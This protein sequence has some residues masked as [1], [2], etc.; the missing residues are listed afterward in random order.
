MINWTPR[1][2]KA[3]DFARKAHDSIGQIRKYSRDPYWTHPERT[4]AHLSTLTQDEDLLI[5]Q[6]FHDIIEDVTPKNPDYNLEL[7]RELYGDRVVA[8]VV[9][10]TDVYTKEAY[11]NWN[12]A[13]RHRFERARLAQIS[14][15][16]QNGKL[17]DI[18]DNTSSIVIN[19]KEFA[20]TYLKEIY[21]L[22]LLLK[23]GDPATHA[24]ALAQVVEGL[25]ELKIQLPVEVN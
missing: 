17:V 12:R 20:K 6:L 21:L 24:E 8:H 5:G 10:L 23:N 7:I 19:D 13:T 16:S 4:M 22:L 25:N 15:S 11:P 9:D 1:L 14:A 18:I 3:R 2:L